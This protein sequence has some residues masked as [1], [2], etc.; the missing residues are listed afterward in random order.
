[1]CV[2]ASLTSTPYLLL[3]SRLL[4]AARVYASAKRLAKFYE[5]ANGD[6]LAFMGKLIGEGVMRGPSGC[7]LPGP[8][9]YPPF[10]YA[11]QH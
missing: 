7:P 2:L 1:M 6:A 3:S 9:A 11:S 5:I 4:V 10:L 8:L